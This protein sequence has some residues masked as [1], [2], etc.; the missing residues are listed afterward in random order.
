[1]QSGRWQ[2]DRAELIARRPGGVS[3][4]GP[5]FPS[6]YSFP[7]EGW[8]PVGRQKEMDVSRR[9]KSLSN[10]TPAFAGEEEKAKLPE[11]PS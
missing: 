6:Q 9:Y 7:S 4:V 10:W 2:P 3:A 8:G 11:D 1:V 5:A